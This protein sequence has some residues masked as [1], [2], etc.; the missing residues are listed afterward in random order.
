M[1]ETIAMKVFTEWGIIYLLFFLIIVWFLKYGI[2]F[3]VKKFEDM[4]IMFANTLRDLQIDHRKDMDNMNEM[5]RDQIK[6]SNINHT[7]THTKL[8]QNTLAHH[9]T[10]T[11]IDELKT[12]II[13]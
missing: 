9:T 13:K 11:K 10:H 3:F 8:E 5:Y 2:P 4:S 6:E 12:L 1:I 7:I